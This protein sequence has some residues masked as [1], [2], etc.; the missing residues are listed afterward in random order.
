MKG[1]AFQYYSVNKDKRGRFYCDTCAPPASVKV[2]LKYSNSNICITKQNLNFT[3][4][5]RFAL[6]NFSNI[7]IGIVQKDGSTTLKMLHV[8]ELFTYKEQS[9]R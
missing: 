5:Y 2:R 4:L 8:R 9:G 6:H 3:L 1:P 7:F